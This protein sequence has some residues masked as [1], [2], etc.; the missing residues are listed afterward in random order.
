VPAAAVSAP[1]PVDG[2]DVVRR[3][4]FTRTE[5]AQTM[6]AGMFEGQR[7]L[8][9]RSRWSCFLDW[10][11]RRRVRSQVPSEVSGTDAGTSEPEPDVSV[12]PANF[13][14]RDLQFRHPNA[15]ELPLA[16]QS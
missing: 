6:D 1:F 11:G 13:D 16:I 9:T 15:R 5:V 2:P 4:R 8:L 12:T 7:F 10:F 3:K 14:L